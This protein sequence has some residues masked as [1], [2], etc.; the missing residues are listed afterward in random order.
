MGSTAPKPS[1]VDTLKKL[2]ITGGIL[3]ILGGVG[4]IGFGGLIDSFGSGAT[5]NK[6][7]LATTYY[8]LGALVL[9]L[10][11]LN[12]VL[13]IG[14][15]RRRPWAWTLGLAL[16]AAPIVLSVILVITGVFDSPWPP[17]GISVYSAIIIYSLLTPDVRSAFGKATRTSA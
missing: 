4:L 12:V 17:L 6:A 16:Y 15:G 2:A 11:V 8:V 1:E 14:I 9:V 3:G 10:G 7:A 13:S 5:P